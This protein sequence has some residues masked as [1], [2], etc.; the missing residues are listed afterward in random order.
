MKLNHCSS[1][2]CTCGDK[3]Y[4]IKVADH[5]IFHEHANVA[6]IDCDISGLVFMLQQQ[7]HEYEPIGRSLS[8]KIVQRANQEVGDLSFE[9]KATSLAKFDIDELLIG[10]L[11]GSGGFSSVFEISS[12]ILKDKIGRDYSPEES[13]LRLKLAHDC[14]TKG[15][16]KITPFAIKHL[17]RKL[18]EKPKR[19]TNGAIDLTLE[20]AYLS[21]L[22][23]PH[24]LNV[25][26]I[27]AD[28]PEGFLEGRHD[29]YFLIV[30]R[31]NGTLHDRILT[32]RKQHK[33]FNNMWGRHTDKKGKK[34]NKLLM[35]RLQVA[36]NIASA[37]AY[38]HSRNLVYRDLK[39]TNIGFGQDDQVKLFDFGLCRELP[40]GADRCLDTVYKMSGGVGTY[41]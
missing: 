41:Q 34:V 14:L 11:L 30:D 9:S 25:H 12:I 8:N 18:V 24:I 40:P 4:A 23:H 37:L 39:P 32:W 38:I 36:E 22:N 15:S 21:S 1:R 33:R 16:H 13:Q 2:S 28:G 27:S 3:K 6:D 7:L 10:P 17:Q 31:L 29:S 35:E 20:A 19:F 26:G 5:S